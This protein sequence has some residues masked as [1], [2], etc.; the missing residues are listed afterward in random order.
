MKLKERKVYPKFTA[1]QYAGRLIIEN[2]N[3]FNAY[4]VS[5]GN[6]QLDVIVKPKTKDRSTQENKYYY[7][8]VVR[9]I[10]E[11]M[12]IDDHEAHEFLKGLFL[13][14]TEQKEIADGKTIIYE[15]VLSITE[16]SDVAFREYW[17]K[18]V[19]WAAL[20][21]DEETGLNITSGLGLYIPLP[22]EVD[23]ENW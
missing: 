21:T 2:N 16:L 12:C 5:L 19:N 17:K 8:V 11:F 6:K 3:S 10:A 18:C 22:N 15:R 7:G 20:P 4:L 1:T 14:T 9:S 23:F 13:T